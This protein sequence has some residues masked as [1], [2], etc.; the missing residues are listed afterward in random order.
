MAQ[1][2]FVDPNTLLP[3]DP[4]TSAKAQAAFENLEAVAEGAPGAPSVNAGWVP[5]NGGNYGT[6]DALI[7]D[8]AVDG[9]VTSVETPNLSADYEYKLVWKNLS[10]AGGQDVTLL[11]D[12]F[13]TSTNAYTIS[14]LDLGRLGIGGISPGPFVNTGFAN[15]PRLTGD[16][17]HFIIKAISDSQIPTTSSS[18]FLIIDQETIRDA[19]K[20]IKRT[21]ATR[22][23]KV[24][25]RA[26][27]TDGIRQ[28]KIY[29]L[30]RLVEGL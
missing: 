11:F 27:V 26:D 29:L 17:T 20:A 3:G 2:T 25:L 18:A 19:Y 16:D 28:G 6:G 23:G 22:V 24:R 15:I 30:R 13:L 4:W 12:L 21:T 14:G 1:W 5:W 8:H 9:N 7:Y 10:R